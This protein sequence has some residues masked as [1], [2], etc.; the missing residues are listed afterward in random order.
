MLVRDPA[1]LLWEMKRL[2]LELMTKNMRPHRLSIPVPMAVGEEVMLLLNS[3]LELGLPKS[4]DLH[5]M[6]LWSLVVDIYLVTKLWWK[7]I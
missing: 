1:G 4:P 5:P 3:R 2:I 7:E 6:T